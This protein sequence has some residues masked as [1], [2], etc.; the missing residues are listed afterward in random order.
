MLMT[1]GTSGFTGVITNV[2]M[3]DCA[4]VFET[5]FFVTSIPVSNST[6][7]AGID[8]GDNCKKVFVG[9]IWISIVF[10]VG[11]VNGFTV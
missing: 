3:N 10:V 11:I 6:V 7:I 4:C 9:S 5:C 1:W 2:V 8:D